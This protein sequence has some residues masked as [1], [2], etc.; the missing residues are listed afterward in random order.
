MIQSVT[1]ATGAPAR[2]RRLDGGRLPVDAMPASNPG[3]SDRI[4]SPIK[5]RVPPPV[6]IHRAGAVNGNA[7]DLTF[8]NLRTPGE[9]CA[10]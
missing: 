3:G 4:G 1:F 5:G 7:E 2:I 8:T 9:R 6:R 10:W